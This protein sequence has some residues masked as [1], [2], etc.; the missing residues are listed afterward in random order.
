MSGIAI[1]APLYHR[2]GGNGFLTVLKICEK[3]LL[4]LHTAERVACLCFCDVTS[5]IM[6]LRYLLSC[7]TAVSSFVC[8]IVI[9]SQDLPQ[10]IRM[11]FIKF[12]VSQNY[13]LTFVRL[14]GIQ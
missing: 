9:K 12:T 13:A 7:A 3:H 4:F 2:N 5:Q 8:R 1:A 11:C 10:C 6:D 14:F